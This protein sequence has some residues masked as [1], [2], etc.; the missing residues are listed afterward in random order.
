MDWAQLWATLADPAL[1]R[2]RVGIV[3]LR[4]SLIIQPF[5]VNNVM[6]QC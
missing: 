3:D 4:R 6:E 1:S 5:C 2:A